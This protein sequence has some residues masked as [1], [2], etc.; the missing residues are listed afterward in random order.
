LFTLCIRTAPICQKFVHTAHLAHF[1]SL[2]LFLTPGERPRRAAIPHTR[3]FIDYGIMADHCGKWPFRTPAH[4]PAHPHKIPRTHS[5][6]LARRTETCCF[7]FRTGTTALIS[8]I[9]SA[10]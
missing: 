2:S 4:F 5:A 9:Y 3:T 10:V 6:Q 7:Y 1:S 8:R